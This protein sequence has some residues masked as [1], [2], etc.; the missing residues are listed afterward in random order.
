M[1]ERTR[2]M[3]FQA[4]TFPQ[5][6]TTQLFHLHSTSKSL[7]RIAR[8]VL[9]ARFLQVLLA[10]RAR[11]AHH[12]LSTDGTYDNA[13]IYST[14]DTLQILA[15]R[16]HKNLQHTIQQTLYRYICTSYSSLQTSFLKCYHFIRT[17]NPTHAPV[18]FGPHHGSSRISI[19]CFPERFW[20]RTDFFRT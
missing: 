14:Q 8:K 7:A 13:Y 4:I 12:L 15:R 17:S 11:I 18:I 5:L 1:S 20:T 3:L 19:H 9:M 10:I 2:F 6:F 16:T